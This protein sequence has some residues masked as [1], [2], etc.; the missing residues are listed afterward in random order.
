MF[1]DESIDRNFND[2]HD[3]TEKHD[4]GVLD[5]VETDMG[6]IHFSDEPVVSERRKQR[7]IEKQALKWTPAEREQLCT[8]IL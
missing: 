2:D 3:M 4:D 6:T 1:T 7:R 5:K 8:Q